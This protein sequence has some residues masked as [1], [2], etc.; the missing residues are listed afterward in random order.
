ME[1][2]SNRVYEEVARLMRKDEDA[3]KRL[4]VEHDLTVLEGIELSEQERNTL[5]AVLSLDA[6]LK[7]N[8]INEKLLLC[9]CP[10]Y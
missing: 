9:S 7:V 8:D 4:L 1:R 3:R 5:S 10:G 6:P 2:F